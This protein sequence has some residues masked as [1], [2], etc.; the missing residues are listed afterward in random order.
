MRWNFKAQNAW[1]HAFSD[2]NT[3]EGIKETDLDAIR[4]LKTK[5]M[6]PL[7]IDIHRTKKTPAGE[8]N[9]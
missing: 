4:G 7:T 8:R 1:Y 9:I 5:Q 3:Y 2:P 6:H